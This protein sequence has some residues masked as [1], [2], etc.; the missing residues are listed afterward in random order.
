[1]KKT[2]MLGGF[3]FFF[4]GRARFLLGNER[5]MGHKTGKENSLGREV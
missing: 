1:M 2:A 4:F 3:F 5:T